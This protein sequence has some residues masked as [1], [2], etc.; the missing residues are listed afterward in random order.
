LAKLWIALPNVSEGLSTI[1]SA[2]SGIVSSCN[3]S[4]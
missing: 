4:F 1:I 2:F 3:L